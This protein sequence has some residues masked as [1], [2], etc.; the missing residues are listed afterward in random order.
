MSEYYGVKRV[1]DS[2]SLEHYGVRGMKWGVRKAIASGNDY[3][4]GK[5]YYKAQKKLEKLNK[6][7]NKDYQRNEASKHLRKAGRAALDTGIAGGIGAAGAYDVGS[8][9]VNAIQSGA[10]KVKIP[11]ASVVAG[12]LG[13]T[14][15][16]VGLGRTAVHAV[17]GIKH[18]IR[19][20]EKANARAVAK[21]DAFK[22]E[23]DAAF[24]GTKYGSNKR[25]VR[26]SDNAPST[27]FDELSNPEFL[28]HY[29][30]RGMKW[31]VR[32]ALDKPLVNGANKKL[33]RQY[34]KAAKKLEKLSERADPEAQF[35]KAKKY[36]KIVK[37]GAGITAG[38]LAG[39]AGG[40]GL[41]NAL[42]PG[43]IAITEYRPGSPTIVNGMREN[44]YNAHM[45]V[46]KGLGIA[47]GI[48]T[49]SGIGTMGTGAVKKAIAKHRM[50]SKKYN[51]KAV[52]KRDAWRNEMAKTFKGTKYAK[53]PDLGGNQ[54]KKSKGR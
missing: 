3:K 6:K 19:S 47:G 46:V 38:G 32:K 12:A 21:R 50:T 24:K 10:R 35:S 7:A 31:G 33:D 43:G 30:I 11:G 17:K 27:T 5:E 14:A 48:A 28:A 23:M 54:K 51:A 1:N 4:L 26:H 34:A 22:R 18:K 52:A 39:L 29:G 49:L 40:A 15:A 13:G 37:V 20:G 53:L 41:S 45:N 36:G 25:K 2:D 42:N 8:R 44:V 16:A 9:V